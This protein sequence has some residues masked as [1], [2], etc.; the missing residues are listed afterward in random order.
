MQYYYNI[1]AEKQQESR[2]GRRYSDDFLHEDHRIRKPNRR[3][4]VVENVSKAINDFLSG[5]DGPLLQP[6][7]V[8]VVVAM[9]IVIGLRLISLAHQSFVFA[10]TVFTTIHVWFFFFF[11]RFKSAILER[12]LT[13]FFFSSLFFTAIIVVQM[14]I[15]LGHFIPTCLFSDRLIIVLYCNIPNN[16]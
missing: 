10:T 7:G 8:L 9:M 3:G 2:H 15:L 4:D 6:R 14:L 16:A 12:K 11:F 5:L 1:L 13:V